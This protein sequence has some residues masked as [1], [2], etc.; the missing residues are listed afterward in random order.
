[1]VLYILVAYRHTQCVTSPARLH[2]KL[3]TQSLICRWIQSNLK[4]VKRNAEKRFVRKFSN[5][6]IALY[7]IKIDCQRWI[8]KIAISGSIF[9]FE[10]ILEII[11]LCL[12]RLILQVSC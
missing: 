5:A 11:I 12:V 10:I 2:T 9:A 1:M 3:L 4:A 7:F 8:L 6:H